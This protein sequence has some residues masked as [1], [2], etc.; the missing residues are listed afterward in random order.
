MSH[1]TSAS[2]VSSIH[3]HATRHFP[4]TACHHA[5]PQTPSAFRPSHTHAAIHAFTLERARGERAGTWRARR[6]LRWAVSPSA[7]ASPSSSN[8]RRRTD[9]HTGHSWSRSSPC[10]RSTSHDQS[11]RRCRSVS[12]PLL[13]RVRSPSCCSE[14]RRTRDR[15][16]RTR[17]RSSLC[18]RSTWRGR[19]ERRCRSVACL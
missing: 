2:L 1:G 11:G 7:A 14:R 13:S 12:C 19:S 16:G 6:R 10:P 4:H 3:T 5:S 17:S 8:A 9:P 15:T 18:P